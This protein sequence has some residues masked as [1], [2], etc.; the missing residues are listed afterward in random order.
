MQSVLGSQSEHTSAHGHPVGE[1]GYIP[2]VL[3]LE[4]VDE[5]YFARAPQ[6]FAHTWSIAQPAETVWAQLAGERPLHW[7]RGLNIAWTS[8]R[9]FGVGTTRRVKV[10]AGALAGEEYFFIWEEGRR[11]AFYIMQA[12]LPVCACVAEDYVVQP[13]GADRC[14]FTWRV[15]LTPTLVGRAGAPLNKLLFTSFFRDTGR[16]F[17]AS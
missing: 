10:L 4:A 15:G 7:C 17:N 6:R 12:N 9:P 11:Y 16:F 5:S 2:P 3:S 13:D 14:R 1:Y 8:A